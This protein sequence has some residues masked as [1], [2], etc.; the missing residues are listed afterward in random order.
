MCRMKPLSKCHPLYLRFSSPPAAVYPDAVTAVAWD[1]AFPVA[2]VEGVVY[3]ATRSCP[4]LQRW[5]RQLRALH[6][7]DKSF[8][9]DNGMSRISASPIDLKALRK[10]GTVVDFYGD[11]GHETD[12]IKG[13][14]AMMS[15]RMMAVVLDRWDGR[16]IGFV[17]FDLRWSV[18]ASCGP[19]SAAEL[20]VELDQ[21]WI[22]PAFRGRRWGELAAIA[23]AFTTRRQV[24]QLRASAPWPAG[25][26][27]PLNVTVGADIYSRSGEA[28]LGCVAEYVAFQLELPRR[29]AR[30]AIAG[31]DLNPRW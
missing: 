12:A 2:E 8:E 17:S 29:G 13:D 19:Y 21:A 1:E 16:P 25:F 15:T 28:L 3:I 5:A 6:R 9:T 24:D 7:K 22:T 4:E 26:S 27:C 30:F 18:W 11:E 23:I 31:V 20:E 10:I 14:F